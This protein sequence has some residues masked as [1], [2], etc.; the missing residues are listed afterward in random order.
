MLA[1]L[2]MD[3]GPVLMQHD[4][5]WRG[6]VSDSVDEKQAASEP[7]RDLQWIGASA[8]MLAVGSL[9]PANIYLAFTDPKYF[10]RF[11]GWRILILP[12]GA[13]LLT[14]FLVQGLAVL[15]LGGI[16]HDLDWA[17]RAEA[18]C[19]AWFKLGWWIL[20]IIVALVL[21]AFF[22]SGVASFL[23]TLSKG[24]VLIAGLLFM[25]LLALLGIGEQLK[26]R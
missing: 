13:W 8:L 5:A 24:T 3:S 14:G 9:G 25:I 19:E 4:S 10:D 18:A 15:W 7:K 16:K 22:F 21:A 17:K 20:G 2:P 11:A 1:A 23:S 6:A 12:F 26:R